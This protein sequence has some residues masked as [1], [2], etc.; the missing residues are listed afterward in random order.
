M[1]T[2][3]SASMRLTALVSCSFMTRGQ[4]FSIFLSS[5][6]IAALSGV[7]AGIAFVLVET[8]GC[9]AAQLNCANANSA[10][11]NDSVTTD[12][13]LFITRLLLAGKEFLSSR[14]H[15]DFYAKFAGES[16]A[17][18]PGSGPKL[19]GPRKMLTCDY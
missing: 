2:A 1:N 13:S 17:I 7:G 16:I 3:S 8:V 18:W 12:K 6:S 10:A 14:C 19:P 11:T 15:I 9:G 5:V 4:S